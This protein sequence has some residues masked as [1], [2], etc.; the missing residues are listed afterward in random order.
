MFAG[1]TRHREP[2]EGE[3]RV[4]PRGTNWDDFMKAIIAALLAV[5]IGLAA[6]QVAVNADQEKRIVVLET[7][8]SEYLANQKEMKADLKFLVK[9]RTEEDAKNGVKTWPVDW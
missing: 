4:G 2:H 8:M 9:R 7:T 1:V 6:N 5:L 3:H